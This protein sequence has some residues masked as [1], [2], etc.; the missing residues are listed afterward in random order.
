VI[1][2]LDPGVQDQAERCYQNVAWALSVTLLWVKRTCAK[3]NVERRSWQ[4]L[5]Y[6]EHKHKKD[7]WRGKIAIGPDDVW[8]DN[9]R[10]KRQLHSF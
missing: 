3:T 10:S 4:S 7:M 5:H 1:S 6:F 9:N 8:N 2:S